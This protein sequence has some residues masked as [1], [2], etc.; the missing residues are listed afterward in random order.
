MA[1]YDLRPM[2]V[3]DILD[4][5]F[6]L[7]LTRFVTFITIALCVYIPYSLIVAGLEAVK[8]GLYTFREE[9]LSGEEEA[10][11]AEDETINLLEDENR[12]SDTSRY[13]SPGVVWL[14]YLLLGVAGTFIFAILVFPLCIG[15]IIQNISASYLGEDQSAAQSYRRAGKRILKLVM[16]QLLVTIITSIGFL[17]CVIPGIFFTL[18]FILSAVV[19]MMEDTT[20][21]GSLSRS[22]ELMQGNMRKGIGLC[23][24]LLVLCSLVTWGLFFLTTIVSWPHPVLQTV[25]YTL[26]TGLIL[27]LQTAPLVLLYYDLRIRKEGF[28]LER[29]AMAMGGTPIEEA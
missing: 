19:A 9:Q 2:G 13:A 14:V 11:E 7:Y 3:G 15:A 1:V 10:T 24:V 22:K 23:L 8:E 16:V 25:V 5:T 18:W 6:R 4:T 17:L 20:V 26:L 12:G 27:P 21:L 28:D 29:L